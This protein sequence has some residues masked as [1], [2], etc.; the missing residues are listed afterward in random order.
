M[1]Q[2]GRENVWRELFA[3]EQGS[4]RRWRATL[5]MEGKP[6]FYYESPLEELVDAYAARMR[7]L[8]A[9]SGVPGITISKEQI[10]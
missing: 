8:Y 4:T 2:L 9:N 1:P 3:I 6:Q 5:Y 7:F 10:A